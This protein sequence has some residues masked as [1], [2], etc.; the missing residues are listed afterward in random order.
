VHA[1]AQRAGIPFQNMAFMAVQQADVTPVAKQLLAQGKGVA[2]CC[3]SDFVA[4]LA[5]QAGDE[6]GWRVGRDYGL[7]GIANTPWAEIMKLTSFSL[8][9]PAIA[10]AV[11][12]L[13]KCQSPGSRII[14]PELVVRGSTSREE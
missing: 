5:K 6:L 13:V 3:C 1:E 11:A 7:I 4:V 9:E 2:V 8:N 12:D 14:L 10:A